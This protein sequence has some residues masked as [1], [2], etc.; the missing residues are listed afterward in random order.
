MKL[1]RF[2][3][4]IIILMTAVF[5][6]TGCPPRQPAQP[7]QDQEQQPPP[8]QQRIDISALVTQWAESDH[9]NIQLYP[10]KRDDCV[11]CHDGGAFAQQLTKQDQLERDF[12]VA[13]DCR[14]CHTGRGV[15]LMQ[16]GTVNIAT[17]ENVQAGLGAQ[18]LAC[19]N[20]RRVPDIN[21]QRRSAPHP[22]SQGGVYTGTGGIR[23]EGF[24][25][26]NSPHAGIQNT[27][28]ACHMTNKQGFP[29]HN[30]A[31]DNAQAACGN[32]HG[33]IT[34]VNLKAKNDHDGNGTANGFQDE[35]AGL[36]DLLK[37]AIAEATD[38]ATIQTEGG[39][40]QFIDLAG[41]QIDPAKIPNEVYQ[42]GYNHVLVSN[43]GS[44]GIHNPVFV[45]Q[46]L[47]Q[48]YRELTGED[49]PNA[50]VR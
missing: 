19:H 13:I 30:F 15:E 35:V 28:I 18:C 38:G 1:K 40:I 21:D 10:A 37:N 32:C 41:N 23:A 27:C 29:S 12:N 24:N 43:D 3:M 16:A 46:L 47:Q 17:Q 7:P 49:V 26:S 33:N 5:L 14:V 4:L 44:L 31:V 48:S 6:L 9:A 22:S 36:L 20:E 50:T 42:A 8:Q 39:Q 11:V 2:I 25:Y 34:D 45:I